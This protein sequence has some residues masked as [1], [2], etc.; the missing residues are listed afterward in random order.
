MR[1][2]KGILNNLIPALEN[3]SNSFGLLRFI[4][5]AIGRNGRVWDF[6]NQQFQILIGDDQDTDFCND[7]WIR[8]GQLWIHFLRIFALVRLKSNP[9]A[10]FGK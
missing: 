3:T 4:E 6:I 5:V 7:N 9:M 1:S 2:S 10:N 8:R